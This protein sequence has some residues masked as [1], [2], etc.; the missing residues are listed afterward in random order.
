MAPAASGIEWAHVR[1]MGVRSVSGDGISRFETAGIRLYPSQVAAE[2]APAQALTPAQT[3]VFLQNVLAGGG[4]GHG[5]GLG[6]DIGQIASDAPNP[7]TGINAVG[8]FFQRLTQAATWERAG[9]AIAG[10]LLLY[11][12]LKA[13]FPGAVSTVTGPVKTAVKAGAMG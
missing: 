11:V 12:A 1:G 6:H 9:E 13:M 3:D 10:G 5:F 7:L 4:I 2:R 8:D